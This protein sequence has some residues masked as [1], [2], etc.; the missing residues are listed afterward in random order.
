M[1]APIGIIWGDPIVGSKD[2]RQGK[3]GIYAVVT[4]T[5]TVTSI[6]VQVWFATMYSCEDG[7]NNLYFD[8]GAGVS[9]ASTYV[10]SASISHP[11]RNNE[12]SPSNQT[13]IFDKTYSYARL[14]GEQSCNIYAKY[15]GIDLLPGGTMY[16]NTSVT[17]PALASYTVSYNANGG[18]GAPVSQ[19]KYYGKTLTLSSTIPTRNG[20]I[21]KGWS[22]SSTATSASWSAGGSSADAASRTVD[23][24]WEAAT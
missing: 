2:T 13:K 22:A 15:N 21:F 23:A 8:I 20:Y 7:A 4:N 24:V 10:G 18:S 16:V 14:P 12:W 9:S 5:D 6:N 3:I 11:D 19:L 1:A 17:I